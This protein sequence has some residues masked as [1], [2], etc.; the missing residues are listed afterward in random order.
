M[1]ESLRLGYLSKKH[2]R[3]MV[4]IDVAKTN[5]CYDFFVSCGWVAA[6]PP[7]DAPPTARTR[8]RPRPRPPRARP[9]RARRRRSPPRPAAASAAVAPAPLET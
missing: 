6:A 8:S 2:A 1:R 3:Q 7:A 5:R 9:P 4:R